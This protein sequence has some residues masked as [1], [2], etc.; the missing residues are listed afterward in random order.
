MKSGR[1]VVLSTD[2]ALAATAGLF[3]FGCHP[4]DRVAWSIEE[5][6]TV[7]VSAPLLVP[8]ER[9]KGFAFDLDK[10]AKGLLEA[11]KETLKCCG[12]FELQIDA[13]GSV[14]VKAGSNPNP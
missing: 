5:Y 9:A 13:S 12:D 8:V 3:C 7:S 1:I 6:G 10:N 14:G 4:M 2:L 11:I